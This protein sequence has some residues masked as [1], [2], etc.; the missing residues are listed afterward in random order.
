M[1]PSSPSSPPYPS[2]QELVLSTKVSRCW[3]HAWHKQ[4]SLGKDTL[5]FLEWE[6]HFCLLVVYVCCMSAYLFMHV[7][8]HVYIYGYALCGGLRI[9][10]LS[11][12]LPYFFQTES[13]SELGTFWLVA[14]IIA[15]VASVPWALELQAC[16][17]LSKFM[18]EPGVCK[19]TQIK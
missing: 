10:Y 19:Q 18:W 7:Y 3:V 2:N 14:S 16:T 12:S 13:L 1:A 8:I 6:W 17:A 9:Q 4:H 11:W 5:W 15:P